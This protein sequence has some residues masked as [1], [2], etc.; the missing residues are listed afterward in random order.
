MFKTT[1]MAHDKRK[2]KM[3]KPVLGVSREKHL[4]RVDSRKSRKETSVLRTSSKSP[5]QPSP[6][7]KPQR[8]PQQIRDKIYNMR[9]RNLRAWEENRTPGSRLMIDSGLD[10]LT[11]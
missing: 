4:R 2:L 8:P 7:S 3:E 10:N 1:D 5:K 6:M 11:F 9:G